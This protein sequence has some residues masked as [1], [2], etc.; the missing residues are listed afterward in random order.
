MQAIS[1]EISKYLT[2]RFLIFLSM[3]SLMCVNVITMTQAADDSRVVSDQE[4]KILGIYRSESTGGFDPGSQLLLTEDK[5]FVFNA[6]YSVFSGTW[7]LNNGVLVLKP[8]RSKLFYVYGRYR[9]TLGQTTR[10]RFRGPELTSVIINFNL[11]PENQR[12]IVFE[13]GSENCFS[14]PYIYEIQEK[15]DM[16]EL[17]NGDK[18]L[19]SDDESLKSFKFKNI[20][21]YNDFQIFSRGSLHVQKTLF[22]FRLVE[23]GLQMIEYYPYGVDK[24]PETIP[25]IQRLD[26]V[27]DQKLRKIQE[28]VKAVEFPKELKYDSGYFPYLTAKQGADPEE[29]ASYYR[30]E[31]SSNSDVDLTELPNKYLFTGSCR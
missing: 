8:T 5:R 23:G 1:E 24:D 28:Q 22:K 25:L 3:L 16:L 31:A 19:L 11:H 17:I 26:D 13:K 18:N 29:V 12:R 27:S 20:H 7:S 14:S 9:E 15:V 21:K 30:I 6:I 4:K 10:V 2:K